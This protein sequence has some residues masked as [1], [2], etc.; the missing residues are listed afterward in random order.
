MKTPLAIITITLLL[1][2][3]SSP[4]DAGVPYIN[5][6][7]RV[8][9]KNGTVHEGMIC[10]VRGG[11]LGYRKNGFGYKYPGRD[12][13]FYNFFSLD[14]Y[15]YHGDPSPRWDNESGKE[16]YPEVY[17]MSAP[18]YDVNRA[19]TFNDTTLEHSISEI[20]TYNYL[21]F[22]EFHIFQ[23][24]PLSLRLSGEEQVRSGQE[25]EM[26]PRVAI[27]VDEVA[28]FELLVNPHEKWLEVVQKARERRLNSGE[29]WEDYEEP[30]WYHEIRADTALFNSLAFRF[31]DN[32]SAAVL[33][34]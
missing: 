25:E 14:D 8:S 20:Y 32:R 33:Q 22:K 2:A 21:L 19:S 6:V 27:S 13:I 24:L 4:Q 3:W 23:G 16:Q 5:A 31:E 29:A 7:C 1:G 15:F 10:I 18:Y 12:N 17:F 9:L 28:R 26:V 30:L 34:P 11:Y